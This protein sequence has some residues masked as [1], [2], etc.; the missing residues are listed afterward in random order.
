[1]GDKIC[2]DSSVF[3]FGIIMVLVGVIFY[4]MKDKFYPLQEDP[5]PEKKEI[6]VGELVSTN[7]DRIAE[8][9]YKNFQDPMTPPTKRLPRHVYPS[10]STGLDAVHTRGIVDSYH[11][12]GNLIRKSDEKIV[13]L[14]GRQTYPSSSRYEYYGAASDSYGNSTKFEIDSGNN[15]ELFD[16]DQVTLDIYDSTKGKFT[17]YMNKKDEFKYSPYLY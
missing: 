15:K 12:I 5:E 6:E 7:I 9:D 17:L 8:Q 10:T 1:M 14:F 16:G 13:K 3:Y 4:F 2:F 11:Y